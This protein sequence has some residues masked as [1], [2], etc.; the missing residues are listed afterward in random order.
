MTSILNFSINNMKEFDENDAVAYIRSHISPE[1][2]E[3]YDDNELFNLIDIVFDYYEANGL[4]DIDVDDDDSDDTV[5]INDV[6]DYAARMLRRDKGATLSA[7]DARPMIEAY[8]EYEQ[9][10]DQ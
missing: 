3:K 9:S 10:L 6:V 1:L 5:D 4:L 7:E 8:F 2:A